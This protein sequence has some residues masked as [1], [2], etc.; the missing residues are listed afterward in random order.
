MS[1]TLIQAPWRAN[2]LAIDLPIPRPPPVI[3]TVLPFNLC[4][5]FSQ[6]LTENLRFHSKLRIRGARQN[7]KGAPVTETAAPF[8]E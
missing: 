5:F 4:I 6:Y 3:K 2:I 8:S 1:V 7:G